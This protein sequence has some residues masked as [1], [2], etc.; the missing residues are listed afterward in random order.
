MYHNDSVVFL[1]CQTMQVFS[2]ITSCD[3][4]GDLYTLLCKV[5]KMWKQCSK[6]QISVCSAIVWAIRVQSFHVW[7]FRLLQTSTY[8]V[9]KHPQ[10]KTVL[11]SSTGTALRCL[12]H[13]WTWE[14]A[15]GWLGERAV[16]REWYLDSKLSLTCYWRRRYLP[17]N[18]A[19]VDGAG[20]AL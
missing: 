8:P 15:S 11:S 2:P 6:C 10:N 7:V 17:T 14:I 18:A 12:T 5:Y 13:S 3:Q 16:V 19:G 20:H 9:T 4:N 1:K